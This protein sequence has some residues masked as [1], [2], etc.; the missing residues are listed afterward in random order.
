MR[1]RIF[2][3]GGSRGNPGPGAAAFW[4]ETQDGKFLGKKGVFLGTTTNNEAEYQA[5]LLALDWLADYRR[6]EEITE[7]KFFLDSRLLVNQLKGSFRVKSPN[8]KPLF[9]KV[10]QK[11]LDL[12]F[13]VVFLFV[14]RQKNAKADA[15]V[16][17]V[18]DQ[19]I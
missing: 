6:K 13:P 19:M 7:T 5:V 15:L 11:Q 12:P 8:L 14:P 17:Q 18:L 4:A 2:A 9:A 1:L 10:K 3:D 16:N